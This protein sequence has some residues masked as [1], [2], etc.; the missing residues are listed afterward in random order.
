MLSLFVRQKL[1]TLIAIARKDDL[2]VVREFLEA[3]ADAWCGGR[4]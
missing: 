2:Q 1:A 3:A 4:C